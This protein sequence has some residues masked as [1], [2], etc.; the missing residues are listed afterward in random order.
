M[1]RIFSRSTLGID[2]AR[3]AFSWLPAHVSQRTRF[4]LARAAAQKLQVDAHSTGGRTRGSSVGF[5]VDL[6]LSLRRHEVEPAC[7]AIN[8]A[9]QYAASQSGASCNPCYSR[10]ER[11]WPGGRTRG[12]QVRSSRRLRARSGSR[13]P[14]RSRQLGGRAWSGGRRPG[15]R[16]SGRAGAH[17]GQTTPIAFHHL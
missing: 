13:H 14:G 12:L 11:T 16:P 17:R 2:Y 8:D 3:A 7:R 9:I 10:G 4:V 15:R 5:P 6:L 1:A